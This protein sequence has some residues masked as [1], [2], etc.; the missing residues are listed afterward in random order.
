[1]VYSVRNASTGSFFAALREGINPPITVIMILIKINTPADSSGNTAPKSSILDTVW[2]TLLIGIS[3]NH[4]MPIPM[5]PEKI[6]MMNVSAL[7][8]CEIFL[9]DA[10]SARRIPISFVL[11]ITEI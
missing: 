10:P 3:S 9:F 5:I 1:M 8:N 11:S 4:V 6:P 7:N 2:M